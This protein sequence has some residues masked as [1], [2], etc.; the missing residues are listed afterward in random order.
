MSP[1]PQYSYAP[2]FIRPPDQH[3][4]QAQQQPAQA[5]APLVGESPIFAHISPSLDSS[6]SLNDA[7]SIVKYK[8]KSAH[9]GVADVN[10]SLSTSGQNDR[11]QLNLSRIENGVDTRTTVMIKNIPNKMTNLDLQN[12]I[13]EVIPRRIDFMYLRIDFRNGCNVGYAFVNF[14]TVQDLLYFAKQRLGKKWD[15]F[16]SQKVLQMSYANYQGKE[17]LIEKFKN[18]NIMDERESWRPCIF[19]S[20]DGPNQGL[21]EPFPA[22][23]HVSRKERN[24][25]NRGTLFPPGSGNHSSSYGPALPSNAPPRR[26]IE[27]H[28][29]RRIKGSSRPTTGHGGLENGSGFYRNTTAYRSK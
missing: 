29:Q 19:Y 13:N 8:Q 10:A 16:A 15:M 2:P 11:N 12:Y 23:T 4:F 26:F 27:D 25:H 9:P 24:S 7:T 28:R 22:P 20:E 3:F 1:S 17:A 21:P 5:I 18:S 6:P 14:I